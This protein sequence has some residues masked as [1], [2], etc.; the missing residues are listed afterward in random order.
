MGQTTKIDVNERIRESQ[1]QMQQAY[2]LHV[3]ESA[4]RGDGSFF[5]DTDVRQR[6]IAKGFANPNLGTV[7]EW[8]RCTPDNVRTAL[9]ELRTGQALTGTHHQT[10]DMWPEKERAVLATCGYYESIW[11]EDAQAVP[12]FLW[13]AKMRFGKTVVHGHPVTSGP[14]ALWVVR[15]GGGG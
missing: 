10:F 13:K 7:R 15:H 14:A 6:L 8:I 3:D 5:R 12:R 1:G 11:A 4:E 9:T 2:T